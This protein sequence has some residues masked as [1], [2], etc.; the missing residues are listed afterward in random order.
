MSAFRMTANLF[1]ATM[2]GACSSGSSEEAVA[3]CPPVQIAAVVVDVVSDETG[4]PLSGASAEFVSD[5]FREVVAGYQQSDETLAYRLAGGFDRPG[6][7]RVSVFLSGY[8]TVTLDG[9]VAAPG[10][11]GIETVLVEVRLQPSR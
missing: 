8:D 2:L 3:N 7:Y 10:A 11:C 1:V 4:R 5:D 9:I 6:I